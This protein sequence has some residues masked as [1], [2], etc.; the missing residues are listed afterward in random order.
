MAFANS[1]GLFTE[2]SNSYGTRRVAKTHE[3]P[4]KSPTYITAAEQPAA[5]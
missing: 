1:S 4:G 2:L 3:V 5:P